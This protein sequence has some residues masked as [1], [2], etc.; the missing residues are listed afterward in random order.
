MSTFETFFVM[1]SKRSKHILFAMILLVSTGISFGQQTEVHFNAYSGLFS[2]HG[3]GSVSHSWINVDPYTSPDKYTSNPYGRQYAFS[4]ALELQEQRVTK[5]K[6]IY[7]LGFSFENLTNKVNI[8]TVTQNGFFYEQYSAN[9]MTRLKN[10]F[11]TLHPFVGHRY[12]YHKIYFDL[13][14]GFDIAFCLQSKETGMATTQNKGSFIVENNIPKPFIDFR[15]GIQVKAYINKLGFLAGYS[16][17]LTNYQ[18]KY[19][20]KAYTGFL[21]FGFCY[22]LK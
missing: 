22:Q 19:M 20:L 2:F 7:G 9:G 5:N 4:Y 17:G 14:A 16:L 10:T 12:T 6:I 18:T 3:N 8:D 21:R 13:L 11:V 1:L 15:P